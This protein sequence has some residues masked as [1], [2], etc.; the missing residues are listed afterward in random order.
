MNT[1]RLVGLVVKTSAS[2]A[3][4]PGFGF[5]FFRGD[6]SGSSHTSDL[7][8]GNPVATRPGAWRYRVG[9]V[10]GWPE[11]SILWPGRMESWICNFAE[12]QHVKSS[13]QIRPRDTQACCWEVKQPT[14]NNMMDRQTASNKEGLGVSSSYS[15]K[16]PPRWPSGKAS[17]LRAK[18]HGFE[19]R[20]RRD[21]FGVESY[22]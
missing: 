20:L 15:T 17:A 11:F 16:R 18:D 12:W 14:N 7:E 10:T 8:I 9:A 6:F 19:S 1:H 3:V 13:E 5:R 4:D 2:R 22:Q 21:F